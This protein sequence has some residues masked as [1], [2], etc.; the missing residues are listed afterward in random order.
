MVNTVAVFPPK[1][2]CSTLDR[3]GQGFLPPANMLNTLVHIG[4]SNKSAKCTLVLN[5]ENAH[6]IRLHIILQANEKN[7]Q[8]QCGLVGK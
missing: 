6:K 2:C 7:G 5:V 1:G 4:D 8:K 3:P